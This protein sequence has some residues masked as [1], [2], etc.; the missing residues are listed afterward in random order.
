MEAKIAKKCR[1]KTIGSSFV[2]LYD[3]C[4]LNLVKKAH[5]VKYTKMPKSFRK[6]I[7]KT[8]EVLSLLR[9]IVHDTS[10]TAKITCFILVLHWAVD[11]IEV[12]Y[13]VIYLV[14]PHQ[15]C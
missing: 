7:Q 5:K 11:V 14:W 12:I 9:P 1:Q 3:R 8:L 6:L 2:P 13:L 15:S 4:V 10:K